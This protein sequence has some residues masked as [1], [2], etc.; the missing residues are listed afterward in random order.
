MYLNMKKLLLFTHLTFIMIKLVN[1][2][3]TRPLEM[4]IHV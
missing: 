1:V 3:C 4:L 2:R